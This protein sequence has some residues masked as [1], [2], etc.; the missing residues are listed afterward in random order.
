[1][2]TFFQ[3]CSAMSAWCEATSQQ[4]HGVSSYAAG[5]ANKV[6]FVVNQDKEIKGEKFGQVN[7]V[8][9]TGNIFVDMNCSKVSYIP[10]HET[11]KRERRDSTVFNPASY[12]PPATVSNH[13]HQHK[14]PTLLVPVPI[15]YTPNTIPKPAQG[16]QNSPYPSQLS[17]PYNTQNI[18]YLAPLHTY[19]TPSP[20]TAPSYDIQPNYHLSPGQQL[21][22]NLLLSRATTPIYASELDHAIS[23]HPS[24]LRSA[25]A[26]TLPQLSSNPAGLSHLLYQAVPD[27]R[28]AHL[29]PLVSALLSDNSAGLS[30]A[31]ILPSLHS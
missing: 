6:N 15:P 9:K 25:L 26:Q 18:Q 14:D 31:D 16:Y 5:K 12:A 30:L 24:L 28:T 7:T 17:I 11:P 22:S 29:P 21:L 20:A 23:A 19:P 3:L 8:S 1:M 13:Q 27:P 4:K 2:F 10:V